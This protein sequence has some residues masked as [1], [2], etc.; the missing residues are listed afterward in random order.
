MKNNII[1]SIVCIL[2]V[3]GLNACSD[4][5]AT[6]REPS[7]DREPSAAIQPSA[8]TESSS[9]RGIIPQAQ[10]DALQSASEV[11]NLLEQ[12]DEERRKQLEAIGN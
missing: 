11:G 9:T 6:A 7:A 8:A 2:G 12:A 5:S 1:A 3:V 10:L 4:E